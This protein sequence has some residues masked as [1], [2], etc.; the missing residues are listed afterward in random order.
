MPP[1][2]LTV[3]APSSKK[4]SATLPG[5]SWAGGCA[6]SAATFP[7]SGP[8]GAALT[9]TGVSSTIGEM[10]NEKSPAELKAINRSS[11]RSVGA[12]AGDAQRLLD[13][14]AFSPTQQTVF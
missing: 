4:R 10:L 5:A 6:F 11:L 2:T 8:A 14:E 13:N 12:S 9:A 1:T 3:I 7:I